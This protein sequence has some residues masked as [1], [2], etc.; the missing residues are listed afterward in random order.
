V[1]AGAI[2]PVTLAAGVAAFPR[3]GVTSDEV[4]M[5]ADVALADACDAGVTV[6][7]AR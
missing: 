4:E 1:P 6:V 3:H 5:A 7:V 2:V